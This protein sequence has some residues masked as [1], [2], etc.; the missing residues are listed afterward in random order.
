MK[1]KGRKIYSR[2]ENLCRHATRHKRGPYTY[3]MLYLGLSLNNRNNKFCEKEILTDRSAKKKADIEQSTRRVVYYPARLGRRCP[4]Q[5]H[6]LMCAHNTWETHLKL[7]WYQHH[8]SVHM[9]KW[10][11]I[12]RNCHPSFS[13]WRLLFRTKMKICQRISKI[14]S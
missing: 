9:R 11:D 1:Q 13:N 14:P 8:E 7:N 3:A 10:C 6:R 4:G 5:T 12:D 2:R